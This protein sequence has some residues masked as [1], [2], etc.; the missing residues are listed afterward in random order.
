M[1][2]IA[3][4]RA[5]ACRPLGG[6]TVAGS[7]TASA[8]SQGIH[9]HF[10]QLTFTDRRACVVTLSTSGTHVIKPVSGK[11]ER[12]VMDQQAEIIESAKNHQTALQETGALAD[13]RLRACVDDIQLRLGAAEAAA[14]RIGPASGGQR[15]VDFGAE[16]PRSDARKLPA[17]SDS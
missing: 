1:V 5:V 13:P 8:P 9:A 4:R 3:G 10:H 12:T 2:R 16:S 15:E 11:S 17:A 14:T 7:A 6:L